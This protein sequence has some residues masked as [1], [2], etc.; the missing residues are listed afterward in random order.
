M[1]AGL[2][3]YCWAA[4]TTEPASGRSAREL[5]NREFWHL[6]SAGRF[7][8]LRS[9]LCGQH[10]WG[11]EV[12]G[13]GGAQAEQRPNEAS[14]TEPHMINRP[15]LAIAATV[16]TLLIS[17]PFS[18]AA[19]LLPNR[20]CPEQN[21]PGDPLRQMPRQFPARMRYS[22]RSPP[23]ASS[24]RSLRA[25]PKTQSSLAV[26]APSSSVYVLATEKRTRDDREEP[27]SS[28]RVVTDLV[29]G[30]DVVT[31]TAAEHSGH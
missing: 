30:M 25:S 31:A 23:G 21:S 2:S 4:L 28:K 27:N 7:G 29:C 19:F 6:F 3:S 12:L 24:R 17:G 20:M 11:T 26:R 13:S 1:D 16:I 15:A 9:C 18:E 14:K 8:G 5:S 22:A 10:S